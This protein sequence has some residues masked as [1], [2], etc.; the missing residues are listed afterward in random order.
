MAAQF[1]FVPV[2]R[3][4][5]TFEEDPSCRY[6]FFHH[7]PD[8]KI[9]CL[10]VR[11]LDDTAEA[12]GI[13]FQKATDASIRPVLE[14][15]RFTD[16]EWNNAPTRIDNGGRRQE[17]NLLDARYA[18]PAQVPQ[19]WQDFARTMQQTRNFILDQVQPPPASLLDCF[20]VLDVSPG[21]LV[22]EDLEAHITA[23]GGAWTDDKAFR[24]WAV[25]VLDGCFGTPASQL[26]AAFTSLY[27]AVFESDSIELVLPPASTSRNAT[28]YKG[29][30][31]CLNY[32]YDE[33]QLKR[34]KSIGAHVETPDEDE[35][36]L[37][38]SSSTDD[39]EYEDDNAS[40][41]RPD[42]DIVNRGRIEKRIVLSKAKT[43]R[44]QRSRSRSPLSSSDDE[45]D[46]RR[47]VVNIQNPQRPFQVHPMDYILANPDEFYLKSD[48]Y[49]EF[50]EP[51]KPDLVC[52][53]DIENKKVRVK[54]V[55]EI[56]SWHE[57][58]R[59][60]VSL[61]RLVNESTEQCVQSALAAL[62]H[63]QK[64][65]LGIVVVPDGMK[66]L[67]IKKRRRWYKI[68]ETPLVLWSEERKLFALLEMIRKALVN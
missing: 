44:R 60:D 59:R 17:I 18:P 33:N 65:I 24:K 29:V 14:A 62:A 66:V 4:G 25:A 9:A 58:G 22:K 64:Y 43:G 45:V 61:K 50:F 3:N 28:I 53:E 32:G 10:A 37:V 23:N 30:P 1:Q 27:P 15:D 49:F 67:Q 52:R 46:L 36:E 42:Q 47:N 38:I 56:A 55:C 8:G 31:H 40:R 16:I 51:H 41:R 13:S 6:S 26:E 34:K 57:E 12:V 5:V 7:K 11:N 48:S 21:T 63:D 39:E 20:K 68:S 19:P 35:P 2:V 54:F